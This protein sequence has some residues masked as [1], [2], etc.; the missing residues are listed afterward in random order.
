MHR[1]T[2]T[3]LSLIILSLFLFSLGAVSSGQAR[4]ILKFQP[5]DTIEEIRDKIEHNGYN[6]TVGHNW[7]Y[8]MSVESKEAFFRRF[9]PI[10][11]R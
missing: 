10:S 3:C 4:E 1:R 8:D 2:K 9:R 11:P 5:G 7:V 6:F